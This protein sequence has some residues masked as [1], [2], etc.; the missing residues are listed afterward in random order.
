[1]SLFLMGSLWTH[2]DAGNSHPT[3]GLFTDAARGVK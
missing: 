2:W 1:M 3:L